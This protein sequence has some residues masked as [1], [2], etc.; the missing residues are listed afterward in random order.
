MKEKKCFICHKV[1]PIDEFYTH[2]G[3][4]DGHLNKCK[5]CTKAYMR[6]RKEECKALDYNRYHYNPTRFL[7]HK[8]YGMKYRC[9]SSGKSPMLNPRY[10]EKGLH[11]TLEEWMEWNK[12]TY[13]TFISLYRIWQDSGFKRGLTPSID[14]I[15]SSRGY[16]LDNIQWLTLS[17]NCRKG[18]KKMDKKY[19]DGAF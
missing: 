19:L 3:T 7:K 13:P 11:F 18:T 4:A 6:G 8:Y 10:H 12:K 15:D 5:E 2:K 14:R 1:K 9:C 17:N 16:T